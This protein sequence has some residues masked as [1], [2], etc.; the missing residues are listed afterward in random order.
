MVQTNESIYGKH[1]G[2]T[3]SQQNLVLPG[4]K[5]KYLEHVSITINGLQNGGSVP[6]IANA[7]GLVN[8][9]EIDIGGIPQ[10]RARLAD[11][12]AMDML[13]L[14]HNPLTKISAGDNQ[15]WI[16]NSLIYPCWFPP[17]RAEA[18]LTATYGAVTNADNTEI[19][20]TAEY[21]DGIPR[22]EALYYSEFSKN[23]DGVDSSSFGNWSQTTNLVGNMTGVLINSPTIPGGS[24]LMED[25]TVQQ[26][27]IQGN[28]NTL[29]TYEWSE[30]QNPGIF[31]GQMFNA[32]EE[33]PATTGILDNYRWL[34]LAKEPIPAGTRVQMDIMAG[35]DSEAIRT[36]QMQQVP[37]RGR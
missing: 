27:R 23:T 28:G 16:V 11:I 17:S 20:I 3:A 24:T 4:A 25:G 34:S 21:L 6:T 14:Q 33:S 26:L 32:L 8:P 30:I 35:V 2:F 18:T 29:L 12:Y 37:F 13:W 9:L 5:S 1:R 7:L 22:N 15:E 10:V 19:S 31:N 36:I